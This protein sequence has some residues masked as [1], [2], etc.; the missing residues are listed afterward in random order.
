MLG[1]CPNQGIPFH[2]PF[3]LD[4]LYVECFHTEKSHS[5]YYASFREQ[6][7]EVECHVDLHAFQDTPLLTIIRERMW[8]SLFSLRGVAYPH[9]VQMFYLNI[10]SIVVGLTSR[11]TMYSQSFW[12]L[13]NPFGVS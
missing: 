9:Y 3:D 8:E 10:H 4:D 6:R 1:R 12:F 2:G 5:R 11:V 7:V 13:P